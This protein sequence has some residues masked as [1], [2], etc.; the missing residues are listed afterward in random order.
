MIDSLILLDAR[1]EV[2][3]IGGVIRVSQVVVLSSQF[4]VLSS[5]PANRG[6]LW[7]FRPHRRG[8]AVEEK[9]LNRRGHRATQ[10]E[11]LKCRF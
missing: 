6:G 11:T 3:V 2:G 7:R 10:G 8:F 4:P 9:S 5:K 1:H